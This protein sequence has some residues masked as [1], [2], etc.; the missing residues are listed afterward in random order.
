[1]RL[2][3][4]IIEVEVDSTEYHDGDLDGLLIEMEDLA[5]R[6]KALSLSIYDQR[7]EEI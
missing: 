3:A 6:Y 1:M 5:N 4:L 7:I 2:F